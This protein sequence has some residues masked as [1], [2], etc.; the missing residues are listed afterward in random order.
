MPS[1]RRGVAVPLLLLV[2]LALPA[3]AGLPAGPAHA[4]DNGRLVLVLD[5]SGSMKERV[6]GDTKIAIAKRTLRR[7]VDRLPASAPVGLR[8][9]GAR[10]FDKA[11]RGACTDSQLV[12]PIG[13]GNRDQLTTAIKRYRPYGQTPISYSLK[14]AAKDLGD[15]GRRSIL[16]VSDGEETC[17]VDPCL[18]AA[19]LAKQGIDL[20]IDVIGLSVRGKARRQLTC[21]AREGRGT[22]YD[23]DSADD[24]EASLDKLSTRAFRPFRFA[25]TPVKGAPSLGGA[26]TLTAGQYTDT[27]PRDDRTLHYKL[28]RRIPGSTL[29]VGLTA[30][31]AGRALKVATGA[32]Y[33]RAIPDAASCPDDVFQS[34]GLRGENPLLSGYTT[35]WVRRPDSPCNSAP[36]LDLQVRGVSDTGRAPFELVVVEE[37]P[38][39]TTS[40]L[41]PEFDQARWQKMSAGK[42]T[43]GVVP[44]SSLS[45]APVLKPGTYA[46]SILTGETQVVAVDLDWGQRLQVEATVPPR[47]GA[48][49]RVTGLGDSLDVQTLGAVRGRYLS[50]T[51]PGEPRWTSTMTA[52]D[53]AFRA[54]GSTPA[55]AYLNRVGPLAVRP[56]ALPGRQYVALNYGYDEDGTYLL[57]YRLVLKVVGPAGRGAPRYASVATPTPSPSPSPTTQPSAQPSAQASPSSTASTASGP[58][59]EGPAGDGGSPAV[60]VGAGLAALLVVGTVIALA[61]RR[62]S[63]RR[64]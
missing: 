41:P 27:F 11:D 51:L 64:G 49:R 53:E 46:M 32:M 36:V 60:G 50:K 63:R 61:A 58:S 24:L 3:L 29:H 2:C 8:V 38:V 56:A 10:V 34:I 44:G 62:R 5:S 9:Y 1:V 39:A 37:P 59:A 15:S 30:R 16:L 54:G 22:Y 43:R 33:L 17:D 42:P 48:L 12:V 57:P 19:A 14:Q 25:G 23:A 45:D 18:T 40:G 55:V 31:P 7:V 26:P 52:D 35:S 4:A 13:T 20:K 21:I 28:T 47:T 6:G